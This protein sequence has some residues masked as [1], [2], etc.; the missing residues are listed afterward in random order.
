MVK[1]FNFN[2]TYICQMQRIKFKKMMGLTILFNLFS[3]TPIL[4]ANDTLDRQETKNL[5]RPLQQT[6]KRTI[7]FSGYMDVFYATNFRNN[8]NPENSPYFVNHNRNNQFNVNLAMLKA[9]YNSNS[10]RVVLAVQGGT[11]A[12]D[13]YTTEPDY[14]RIL[15]QAF[16]GVKLHKK[17]WVDAGIFDSYIGMESAVNTENLTYSRSLIADNSPYYFTGLKLNYLQSNRLKLKLIV[18]NGWQ[19]ISPKDNRGIPAVGTALTYNSIKGNEFNWSTY[20]GE[21]NDSVVAF[22]PPVVVFFNNFYH[23]W[24]LSEKWKLW[25]G[26]DVGVTDLFFSRLARQRPYWFGGAMILQYQWNE[27]WHTALRAEHYNDPNGTMTQRINGQRLQA[28][29]FSLNQDYTIEEAKI[30]LEVKYLTN[31]NPVF[32]TENSFSNNSLML[33]AGIVMGIK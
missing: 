5:I 14:L 16:V 10:T 12:F 19:R 20:L 11:Y 9:E 18:S 15:N 6:P 7:Q 23:K 3:L 27:K 24:Q 13:N 29:G 8:L 26:M 32:R 25:S 4:Y 2:F 1:R 28:S 31:P 33:M 22:R 30:R 21:N 17:L